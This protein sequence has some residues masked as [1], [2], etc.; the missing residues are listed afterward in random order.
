MDL[1]SLPKDLLSSM[2][3]E[4]LQKYQAEAVETFKLVQSRYKDKSLY[5]FY[6][7]FLVLIANIEKPE[8]A[9]NIIKLEIIRLIDTEINAVLLKQEKPEDSRAVPEGNGEAT[10]N[11]V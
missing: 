3:I 10:N 8:V 7:E 5:D 9:N 1:Q 6:L 2:R 4:L 11:K